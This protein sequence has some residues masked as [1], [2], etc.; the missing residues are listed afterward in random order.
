MPYHFMTN[1]T[2]TFLHLLFVFI[3]QLLCTFYIL[4][5]LIVMWPIQYRKL[6]T[7][8]QILGIPARV[9]LQWHFYIIMELKVLFNCV[10]NKGI[11][12]HFKVKY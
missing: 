11:H 4:L 9:A 1:I 10:T 12:M 6:G 2:F 5:R 3:F 7:P 8:S